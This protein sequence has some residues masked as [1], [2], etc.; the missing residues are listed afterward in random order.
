MVRTL[1]YHFLF[2]ILRLNSTVFFLT[3]LDAN[4]M[5]DFGILNHRIPKHSKFMTEE[6]R[7]SSF[8]KWPKREVIDPLELAKAGFYYTGIKY[9]GMSVCSK[10]GEFSL[11]CFVVGVEDKVRCYHCGG[12]L[13]K[14][15]ANDD[16]WLEHTKWFSNC[17][18]IYLV[19]GEDF[20]TDVKQACLK[21]DANAEV[22]SF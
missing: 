4:R 18:F 7:I 17:D 11:I 14:W 3:G 21:K 6:S 2:L 5:K 12:G 8:E 9:D 22:V 13:Q 10:L 20:I 19:K 1:K 15:K 16:P